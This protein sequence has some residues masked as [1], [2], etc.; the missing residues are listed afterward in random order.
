MRCIAKPSSSVSQQKGFTLLELMVVLVIIGS[1]LGMV[2][3]AY[4]VDDDEEAVR[5]DAQSVR[6]FIQHQI[7]QSWLDG[8]TLGAKVS[9]REI[10]LFEFD[11]D[12]EVW[13]ETEFNWEPDSEQVE[14]SLLLSDTE[15]AG[16]IAKSSL[17]REVDL[18]FVASGEYSPFKL[19][20]RI[21]DDTSDGHSFLLEGDGVN[22]LELSEN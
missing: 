22:A 6:L 18:A 2:T 3:V 1:L 14:V 19:N 7:D 21:I 8:K 10:N 9:A 5:L 15:K 4:Q 12:N 16:D 13:L 20:I 17:A 11:L